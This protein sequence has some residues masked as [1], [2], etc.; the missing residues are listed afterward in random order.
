MASAAPQSTPP[1]NENVSNKEA[2]RN[3][4]M[5]HYCNFYDMILKS[6]TDNKNMSKESILN[7]L[8]TLQKLLFGLDESLKSEAVSYRDGA[9]KLVLS[10]I[11]KPSSQNEKD[12]IISALKAIKCCV[13]NC[14][15]GRAKCGPQGVFE[16]LT[17]VYCDE[18]LNKDEQIITEAFTTTAAICLGSDINALHIKFCLGSKIDEIGSYISKASGKS[19]EQKVKDQTQKT[20]QQAQRMYLYLTALFDAMKK[21]SEG[22]S[23][24]LLQDIKEAQKLEHEADKKC[25]GNSDDKVD[26][27]KIISLYT[28]A[29]EKLT[30]QQKPKHPIITPILIPIIMKQSQCHFEARSYSSCI[31]DTNMA[32]GILVANNSNGNNNDATNSYSDDQLQKQIE[33]IRL[34]AM[35]ESVIE[36]SKQQEDEGDKTVMRKEQV[37]DQ[38][39]KAKLMFSGDLGFLEELMSKIKVATDDA[40]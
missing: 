38:I 30:E 25:G 4:F 5:S 2:A 28:N 14:P 20:F 18:K 9:M 10:V 34:S 27:E 11:D 6:T 26:Y 36:N 13:V 24:E 39:E 35:T 31:Q 37:L 40:N 15:V 33:K 32:L 1:V 29:T 7:V 8:Q 22:V 19:E 21:D 17:D 3:H 23:L 12:V 16:F